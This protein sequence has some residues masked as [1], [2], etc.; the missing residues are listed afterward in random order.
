M[1]GTLG[2]NPL[3]DLTV[4]RRH[5]FPADIE[6]LLLRIDELGRAEGRWP[7][8]E[9]WPYGPREFDWEAGRDLDEAIVDLTELARAL[10]EGRGDDVLIDPLTKRPLSAEPLDQDG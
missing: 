4:H 2:D 7:L 8:G 9:N 5:P 10:E 6:E 3:S 1:N